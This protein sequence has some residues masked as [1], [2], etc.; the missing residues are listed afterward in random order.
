MFYFEDTI[1]KE[2]NVDQ[3]DSLLILD[4]TSCLDYLIEEPDI[5]KMSWFQSL[6]KQVTTLL[7]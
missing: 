1:K 7:S 4:G 5:K 2:K 3:H 6:I